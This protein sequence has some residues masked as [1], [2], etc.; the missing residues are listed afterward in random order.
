MRLFFC[1]FLV[2]LSCL[3]LGEWAG[4]GCARAE[5][6]IAPH[7]ALYTM[8]L[9]A[10]KNGS[11]ITD[12]SGRLL[13]EWRDMCDGW[14]IQQHMQLHFTY[15]EGPEEDIAST[16]LTW[17]AKDGRSYSFTIRRE[18][19]GKETEFYR[20][21]ASQQQDG[22]V[23]VTYTAPKAKTLDFYD[24]IVLPTFIPKN[25]RCYPWKYSKP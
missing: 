25:T 3:T 11:G 12:L 1:R 17:E 22:S 9:G 24:K 2:V 23:L 8:S 15:A 13:F 10:I 20:G 6:P 21:K 16:E 14:A 5:T 18:S 4:I 7:R 19:N